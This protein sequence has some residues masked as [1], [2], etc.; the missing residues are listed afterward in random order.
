MLRGTAG[1]HRADAIVLASYG[2][3]EAGSGLADVLFGNVAPSGRLP[4][5]VFRDL[6]QVRPM[7]DYDLTSQPGR[8]H[9]YYD[10]VDTRGAPQFWLGYGLS[11][12][13]FAYSQLALAPGNGSCEYAKRE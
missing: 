12:S 9:L 8:T 6:S 10:A 7:G 4:F 3:E 1:V 5:T 11:Y 2:G 13:R